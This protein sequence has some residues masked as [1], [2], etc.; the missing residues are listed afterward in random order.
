MVADFLCGVLGLFLLAACVGTLARS[1][2]DPGIRN[3]VIFAWIAT[4]VTALMLLA[5]LWTGRAGRYRGRLGVVASAVGLGVGTHAL[6]VVAFH[7]VSRSIF[8][9]TVPGLAEHFLL[10]PLVLFTTAV[11]LP[12]G[13]MGVSEGASFALFRLM[14]YSGGAIAMLGFR[15]L[16]FCGAGIGAVVYMASARQIRN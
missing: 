14:N 4:G 2:L 8:G 16:Q 7:A 9:G 11:P 5:G 12:F 10:V 15:I 1:R 6:N 3:L 13:A